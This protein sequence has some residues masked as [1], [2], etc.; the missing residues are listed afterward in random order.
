M[1]DYI[2]PNF[3][4]RQK[5]LQHVNCYVHIHDLNCHCKQPLQHII[6]QIIH[7]EPTIKKWLAT[8]LE[9]DGTRTGDNVIDDFG[10][11]ELERLFAEE[12]DAAT[13]EG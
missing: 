3:T 6:E 12:G 11:G 8:T 10:P 4:K 1:S 2:P 9:E 5:D 7:Q 13:K